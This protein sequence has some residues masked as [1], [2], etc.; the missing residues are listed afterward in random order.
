M[1][2]KNVCKS[3]GKELNEEATF[4]IC[5]VCFVSDDFEDDDIWSGGDDFP[6]IN[7]ETEELRGWLCM[8]GF[9]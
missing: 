9:Y 4:S 8:G 5:E 3:C 6:L 1:K 7:S 2:T